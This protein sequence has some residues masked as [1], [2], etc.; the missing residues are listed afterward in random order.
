LEKFGWSNGTGLGVTGD[1]R[2]SHLKVMHKLDLM[3]IGANRTRE[4]DEGGQGKEYEKLLRRLND[5]MPTLQTPPEDSDTT[6]PVETETGEEEALKKKRKR[7]TQEEGTESPRV[8]P[9][10]MA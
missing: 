5:T 6:P 2:T 7:E 4:G 1:G 3:G 10:R 9:R 8:A